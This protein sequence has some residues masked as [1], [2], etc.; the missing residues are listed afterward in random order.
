MGIRV[1]NFD[2]A[3]MGRGEARRTVF[4]FLLST[5]LL[6]V[7]PFPFSLIPGFACY[8]SAWTLLGDVVLVNRNIPH[9]PNNSLREERKESAHKLL[10]LII[11]LPTICC[12]VALILLACYN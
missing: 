12:G 11:I 5:I 10:P 4:W 3:P 8:L 9:S 6:F 1:N 2:A 7:I